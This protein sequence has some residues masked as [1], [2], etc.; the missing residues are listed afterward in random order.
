MHMEAA[1]CCVA[2][3]CLIAYLR[4]SKLHQLATVGTDSS[5]S[6]PLDPQRLNCTRLHQAN[7]VCRLTQSTYDSVSMQLVT[8]VNVQS[9][10]AVYLSK[11]SLVASCSVQA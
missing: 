11:K 9:I 3:C 5:G 4:H 7:T 10:D 1:T 8:A 6:L 2:W